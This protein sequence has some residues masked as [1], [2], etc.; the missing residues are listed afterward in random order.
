MFLAVNVF[1]APKST[2][3]DTLIFPSNHRVALNKHAQRHR[4]V[5]NFALIWIR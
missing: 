3:S 4:I 5:Q 2:N 1:S